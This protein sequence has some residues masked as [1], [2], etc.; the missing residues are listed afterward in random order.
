[1]HFQV[2]RIRPDEAAQLRTFRL[3]ALAGSPDAFGST[4]AETRRYPDGY[5]SERAAGGCDG[6]Q[7]VVLVAEEGTHWVG[8]AG[9]HVEDAASSLIELT[10]L[11][12]EPAYR[13]RGIAHAL[14]EAV[15]DWTRRRGGRRLQLW[16]TEGNREAIGLYTGLG[17]HATG[18]S[19]PVRPGTR[20]Q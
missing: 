17:F 4:L 19:Q 11:W 8:M 1:M 10:S 2:R 7:R 3:R 16:V 14:C 9:A 18:E 12:V 6:I 13:G 15:L 20:A 5:W